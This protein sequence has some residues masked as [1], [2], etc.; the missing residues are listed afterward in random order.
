VIVSIVGFIEHIIVAKLY[1]SKHN[2][3]ISPNRELVALGFANLFGS[4]FHTFPT[5]GSL[6]RSAVAD[7]FGARSQ[8]FGLIA[9]IIIAITIFVLGPVFALLP[10]VIMSAII[11]VASIGLYE[12]HD[13]AFLLRVRVRIQVV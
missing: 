12:F 11:I 13:A 7:N 8:I 10:R 3:H 9:G 1:A 4:F 6:P 5:F 2:Y